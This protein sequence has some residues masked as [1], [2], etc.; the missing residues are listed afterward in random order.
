MKIKS[1]SWKRISTSIR[2]PAEIS[3]RDWKTPP[4]EQRS[5][6]AHWPSVRLLVSLP[7]AETLPNCSGALP[8]YRVVIVRWTDSV[9]VRQ[10][11]QTA[12]K[13]R[14]R[15]TGSVH[16][17]QSLRTCWESDHWGGKG[18]LVGFCFSFLFGFLRQGFLCVALAVLEP[19]L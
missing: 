18:M 12:G 2:K 6:S 15:W 19:V 10:S 9:H 16:V 5:G 17:R 8:K 1:S 7:S 13:V 14:V 3:R 4:K 11:P